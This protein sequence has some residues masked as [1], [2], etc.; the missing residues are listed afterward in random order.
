MFIFNQKCCNQQ[1]F[2]LIE[3]MIAVSIIAILAAA[4]VPNYRT[5]VQNTRV[6]TAS[7]SILNGLQKA[8]SEALLRNASVRF[9][10]AANSAWSIACVTPVADLNGDGTDDCPANIETRSSEEGGTQA[11]I[12]TVLPAGATDVVFTSLGVQ[13][14]TVA[15]QITQI[16]LSI[17]DSDRPL[18]LNIAGGGIARLCDPNTSS[19]DPRHC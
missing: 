2:S 10:L 4:A 18:R 12:Q 13:S 11:A 7:E 16:D 9:S 5:W 19:T 6:R 14:T 15:N 17:T 3:L 1:G 8:R